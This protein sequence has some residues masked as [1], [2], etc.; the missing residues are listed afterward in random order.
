MEGTTVVGG[1]R[2]IKFMKCAVR[3]IQ[4]ETKSSDSS[5][6]KVLRCVEARGS[7]KVGGL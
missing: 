2:R 4:M 5:G 6:G 7:S 3:Q 1:S